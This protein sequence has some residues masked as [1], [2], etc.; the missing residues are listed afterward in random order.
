MK[1]TVIPIV[2]GALGTIPE[3]LVK[4]QEDLEI[5]VQVETIQ[6]TALLRLGRIL[7]RVLGTLGGLLSLKL[8][9]KTISLCWC[10][11]L[12]KENNNNKNNNDKT[13]EN[14]KL[15]MIEYIN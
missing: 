11:K 7:T 2:V 4:R 3:G 14:N 15:N 13:L 1:V 10:E 12:S 6:T 8:R 5:R 9:W